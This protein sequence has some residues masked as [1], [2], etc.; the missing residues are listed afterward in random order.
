[1]RIYLF[2]GICFLYF[3]SLNAAEIKI[4]HKIEKEIITNIDIKNELR[5]LL[6]LSNKLGNL[7][8][9]RLFAI[10]NES[11]IREK[12][13]YI[14][15]KKYWD[16]MKISPEYLSLYIKSSYEKLGL[17][18]AEEFKQYLKNYELT[19]SDIEK[20]IT[21]QILW[22]EMIAQKYKNQIVINENLIKKKILNNKNNATKDYELSEII[23]EVKNKNEIS[24]KYEEILKSINEVGFQNS[25]SIFSF[26]D[27]AKVG[28]N[29]GWVN[30]K[31]LNKVIKENLSK[32]D[33]GGISKP[34][35]MS[36][37]ILILKINNIRKAETQI[38]YESEFKKAIKYEKN[39]QI[40]Q[41]SKIY[42]NKIKKNLNLNE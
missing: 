9:E 38:D 42:F 15:I 29:I 22:N 25:A 36:S 27:T 1:M 14:E 16:V 35:L 2:I 17:K 23:F 21:I 28:G 40:N 10:S 4:I 39:R 12:I 8:K 11:I 24:K 31:S 37:G 20:K 5:Y 3:A 34:I 30:E 19:F 32:L 33:I 18:S 26:S 13:K 6:A 7:D 41:Y